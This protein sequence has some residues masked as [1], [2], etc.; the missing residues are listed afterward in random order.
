MSILKKR[1][2]Q[3]ESVV[4]VLKKT[5]KKEFGSKKYEQYAHSIKENIKSSHADT[6]E[7]FNDIYN[8]LKEKDAGVILQMQERLNTTLLE[9]FQIG[10][11]YLG[12]FFAYLVAFVIISSYA[13]QMVAIPGL[14]VISALFLWK[15]YEYVV[16]K[17]CYVD[18]HIVL[19]Y[20]SVL[21]RIMMEKK[22]LS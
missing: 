5:L 7:I 12:A 3:D 9:S 10:R 11:G 21:E 13:V 22:R 4:N 15:T 17:F 19:V 16:N 8:A 2:R 18:V 6:T 14:L 1:E 20:K